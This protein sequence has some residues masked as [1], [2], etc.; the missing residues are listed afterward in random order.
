[1]SDNTSQGTDPL[2]IAAA[3]C[4]SIS[5]LCVCLCYGLPFNVLG[6]V[7]GW[8]A[9]NRVKESGRG[10]RSLALAGIGTG[11]TSIAIAIGIVILAVVLQVTMPDPQEFLRNFP[12]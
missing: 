1:M 7:L 6:I 8:V 5:L 3:A 12:R 9:L 2:A 11:A 10:G 4:G